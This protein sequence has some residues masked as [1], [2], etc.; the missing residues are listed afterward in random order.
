MRKKIN[1]VSVA[2]FLKFKWNPTKNDTGHLL[3]VEWKLPSQLV[4]ATDNLLKEVINGDILR[5]HLSLTYLH[6]KVM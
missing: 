5:Q 6:H 1:I 4:L 3:L 2:H